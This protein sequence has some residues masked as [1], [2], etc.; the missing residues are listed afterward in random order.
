MS[1]GL[2]KC[3]VFI[4]RGAFTNESLISDIS[5]QYPVDVNIIGGNITQTQG[6]P[7]GILMVQV[8]GDANQI[9]KAET[10]MRNVSVEVEVIRDD[11]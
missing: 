7:L 2:G 11:T 9:R 10:Y 3:Y 4:L 6:G 5:K 1:S 8:K